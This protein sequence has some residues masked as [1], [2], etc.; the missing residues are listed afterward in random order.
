MNT[1]KPKNDDIIGKEDFE[2][3]SDESEEQIDDINEE[4][5][6]DDDLESEYDDEKQKETNEEQDIDQE[7]E[8]TCLY[9]FVKK[10]DDEASEIED[11]ILND[12]YNTTNII[13]TT[14]RETKPVLTKYERVV[15]LGTRAKQLSLGAKPMLL[16]VENMSPIQI[17][18]L[19]LERG[20]I[21]FIIEKELPN[22]V[23]ER[24]KINELKIIIVTRM[25]FL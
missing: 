2:S 24:W 11:E 23:K 18:K 4:E 14:D 6:E 3:E 12:D 5:K 21:P 22:G 20:V 15:V 9:N 17:A 19:E 8:N 7:D 13:K 10:D 16:N 25:Y 1:P